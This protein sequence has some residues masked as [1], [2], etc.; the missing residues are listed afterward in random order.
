MAHNDREFY[1]EGSQSE[2]PPFYSQP[3]KPIKDEAKIAAVLGQD[4]FDAA[5]FEAGAA[6]FGP[7][8]SYTLYA[9]LVFNS[10]DCAVLTFYD[11]LD[12]PEDG[13]IPRTWRKKF[14]PD[15]GRMLAVATKLMGWI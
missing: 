5:F 12:A 3:S 10:R 14:D 4:V 1:A 7:A 2:A 9:S 13:P 8:D 6:I 15:E 11:T